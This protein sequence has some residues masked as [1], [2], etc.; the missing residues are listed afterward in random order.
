[1]N[2]FK[3]TIAT[4]DGARF[5][6]NAR[7]VTVKTTEGDVQILCGHADYLAALGTGKANLVAEDGT[8]R[9]AALSGGFISCVGGTVDIVATTFEFSEDID[10]ARAKSAKERAEAKLSYEKDARAL[11]VAKAKLARALCRISVASKK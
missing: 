6:G 8:Q 5:S 11:N 7:S 10:L 3:L 9:T 4:P 1:M 2:T